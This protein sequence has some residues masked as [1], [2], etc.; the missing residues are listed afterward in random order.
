MTCDHV[1]LHHPDGGVW[2]PDCGS[3]R[4]KRPACWEDGHAPSVRGDI[5]P[6]F[7]FS[8]GV[9][10][11]SR[12]ELKELCAREGLRPVDP[13][14]ADPQK[15]WDECS[16]LRTNNEHQIKNPKRKLAEFYE[17]QIRGT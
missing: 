7:N 11:N 17:E 10:I 9:P 1:W 3:Q 15:A 16:R 13:T 6:H 2:C 4:E 5:R 12:R 14:L 8:A